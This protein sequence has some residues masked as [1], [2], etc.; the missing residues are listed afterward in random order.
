MALFGS[1][2][3]TILAYEM[4]PH[5]RGTTIPNKFKMRYAIFTFGIVHDSESNGVNHLL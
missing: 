4:D 1:I 5:G 3:S 2:L